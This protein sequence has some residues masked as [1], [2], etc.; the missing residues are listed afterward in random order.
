M[1]VATAGGVA[2]VVDVAGIDHLEKVL[3][4]RSKRKED[5]PFGD[6]PSFFIQLEEELF[7]I[8]LSIGN[9]GSKCFTLHS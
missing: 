2:V 5:V 4:S 7:T 9:G 3:A 1:A 8:H 6:T